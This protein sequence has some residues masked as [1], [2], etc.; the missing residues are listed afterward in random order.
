[1]RNHQRNHSTLR[2]VS[3]LVLAASL[4]LPLASPAASVDLAQKP[5]ATATTSTVLPNL[6]FMLDDS[7]S[8]DWDYMP[9]NAKN[10][11]G[12]Y[13][14]NNSHCNG[15]YYDP[16]IT[17][18]P[19]V[20]STGVSYPNASFTAA[21]K[22]GYQTS[23][24]TVNLST[25]FK[26]GSGSG[27]TGASGY[28]GPAFYYTYNGAQT[29]SAQMDYH[30]TSSTFYRECNSSI[31]STPGSGV[32]NKVRL[33][34]TPTTTMTVISGGS[35][36][37]G[38]ITVSGSSNGTVSNI[39]VNGLE[40]LNAETSKSR[41]S[42]TVANN[43]A[44][45]INKCTTVKV[46]NCTTTGFSASIDPSNSSKVIIASPATAGGY[47]PVITEG[48]STGMSYATTVFPTVTPTSVTSIR[49]NGIELLTS[50]P[51][52]P[53][54]ITRAD[55][56]AKIA[57]GINA[58]GYSATVS[59]DV[60]TVTGPVSAST[61]TPVVTTNPSSG[62]FSVD[63]DSFPESTPAKLQNFSNWYSYY[64]NRM[65]MM[66]TG[67][68][69]AFSPINE[70]FRVGFMTMNNNVS[71]DIV[72]I[73]PFTPSQKSSWYSK[74]YGANP[75]NSTPLRE[76]LAKV[77]RLYAHKYGSLTEYTATITVN[78]GTGGSTSV[79]SITVGGVEL[80]ADASI[81]ST[82]TYTV[83]K[84][85]AGQ[86]IDPSEY[87][88]LATNNKIVITGPSS[89]LGQVP[90]VS[91]DGGGLTFTTTAFTASTYTANLNG[92]TPADPVEYSCQQN[93]IILSTDGYWNG[94]AG[95]QVD[96]STPVGN[97][98]GQVARPQ[99]DGAQGA[100]T[101]TTTFTRDNYAAARSDCGRDSS[102]NKLYKVET[103]PEITTC[104]ITTV[105]GVAGS[106]TCNGWSDNGS[107][108]YSGLC[109]RNPSLP[110]PDPSTRVQL[111]T[112]V[113]NSTTVGGTSD[114]LADVAMYYYQSDLRTP[115]LN[116]C[117]GATGND[118]CLNNV[119]KT[120]KDNNG[121]QHMATFTL[122]LG[123][124]GRMAYSASYESDT[125]GDYYSVWQGSTANSA[126]T[127][128]VCAWQ[129]NGT[130]CNWPVPASGQVENID[131]LWHA[132]VDG[133]GSYFSATNPASLS[134]GMAGALA[135]IASRKGSSAAAATS[136][137]NP[138]AG[139]N[140]AYVASY[141]TVKWQGNLEARTINVTNGDISE[142][143][144]WCVESIV[145][146]NCPSPGVVVADNSGAST[147]YNCVT[148]AASQ[149]ACASPG[150]FKNSSECW[151]PMATSCN[152]TMSAKIGPNTTD[153][154]HPCYENDECDTRKIITADSAGTG[155]VDFYYANLTAT[156]KSY[157]AAAHIDMLSQWPLLTPDQQT[158]AEGA[159][160][161]NFMRGQT[162]Y[163]DRAINLYPIDHRLYRYR[164]ATMGD[165][166]E[167]QPIYIGKPVFSYADPGYS[168]FVTTNSGRP[169]TVFMGANDG[170]LHAFS[171][172]TVGSVAG[173]TERW[174][175]VPSMVIPN[176]WKLADWDYA[177]NHANFVNGSPIVSDVCTAYCNDAANAVWKTIL[178]GGLNAGGVGYYALD[179]TNPDAPDLLWEFTTAQDGDIGYSYGNPV[180]TAKADG[181]WV[182]LLTSGH[183]NTTGAN[184]G[185]GYLYVLNAGTGAIISKIGTGAGDA[186]TPSGLAKISA[187]NDTPASN[188]ATYVYG[189]DLL[190]NV[191]RFDINS[192]TTAAI[193]TG[194]VVQFAILLDPSGNPQ[195][196]TTPPVLGKIG[197]KRIIF[198]GTG[199]YLEISDLTDTQQQ[200]LY[201]LKDDN[202]TYSNPAGSPRVSTT[203]VQQTLTESAGVRTA[204][205]NP[206]DFSTGSGWYVDFPDSGERSNIESRL[207]QGTLLVATIVPSDSACSP[208]GYGWLNFFDYQSG[209]GIDN[210]GIVSA[211]YDNSI[212]G[213]NVLYI[214]G[215][216]VIETVTSNNPT[217]TVNDNV[218]INAQASGFTGKRVLW[219]ELNP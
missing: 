209:S 211:R 113:V 106:E 27:A 182:V 190:G 157:F 38:T 76:V 93:F 122:G 50:G 136:T 25:S 81:G 1:M 159:N 101:V 167:S 87:S 104:S 216:P 96:G 197:G 18:T 133:R 138:V 62:G 56:A 175:Y 139:N 85:V 10:F 92:I 129:A 201:A 146:G 31:G 74:L 153:A 115:E 83:A 58:T 53:D 199:K 47:Y 143:A 179:V 152:G 86:F 33:A 195:P 20:T 124:S 119:F 59:G 202:S 51:T 123:A 121:A 80:L 94:N 71:P 154:A 19:P 5:L 219:R 49:V 218:L 204:T 214:D 169:G 171:A 120:D 63:T 194:D 125:S 145:A 112:P 35:G 26:G 151:T 88:A 8:M 34:T 162:A 66:K 163:E 165:A 90:V 15:V 45:G 36:N 148:A 210:S 95:Y 42:R 172:L 84:N 108:T 158:L 215:K 206:V 198:I 212:V 22:D 100:T 217:P 77:G 4:A 111:G 184:P 28:T 97:Q 173:G 176:M 12:R 69:Q 24:G 73:A 140:Y 75:G 130:T 23:L 135:A 126:A 44:N 91:D 213:I 107:P 64:S 17:Y 116:N 174:A 21:W 196:V 160:L 177:N 191:W 141:T 72:D 103:Q 48:S 147:T 117:T 185:K 137:L 164:E 70:N 99:Y 52:S 156:Q 166:L 150:V 155:V 161:V 3:A 170:M 65:L 181:T 9:D 11:A 82:N 41:R 6:M 37:P 89:A 29:S 127:P 142:S 14:F 203:L 68:G 54:S 16:N 30:N 134:S 60:V 168:D 207:V 57:A 109:V 78:T 118:V 2:H 102:N 7:G 180:I 46:G 192:S 32:F 186:T 193:G 178:V 205:N 132:A 131:D 40:I 144:S 39:K 188:R 105:N 128:P 187:W 110:N 61:Y 189:G 183:N 13:G 149:S 55:L 98:D 43:I 200:T 79:D 114:T 208:G 67:V